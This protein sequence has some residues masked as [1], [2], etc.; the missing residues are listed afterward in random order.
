MIC[1]VRC[2][3]RGDNSIGL[4]PSSVRNSCLGKSAPAVSFPDF[5]NENLTKVLDICFL[6]LFSGDGQ[7]IV[8][9]RFT[10]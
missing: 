2:A 5:E 9:A 1:A 7:G 4:R 10:E 3:C 8:R 6:N